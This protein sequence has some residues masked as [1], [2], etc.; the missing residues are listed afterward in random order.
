[1]LGVDRGEPSC[2]L[3]PALPKPKD[4]PAQNF[5]EVLQHK[6]FW[7]V[8]WSYQRP[9]PSPLAAGPCHL[10][11]GCGGR[12]PAKA[13]RSVHLWGH[14]VLPNCSS[15]SAD[16]QGAQAGSSGVENSRGL[17]AE[18]THRLSSQPHHGPTCSQALTR[19][20]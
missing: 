7:W 18:H 16:P 1:M 13:S 2:P 9:Y 10:G 6:G 14:C 5:L 19:T 17:E 3:S 8:A 20:L 12:A 15:N 4:I 11:R